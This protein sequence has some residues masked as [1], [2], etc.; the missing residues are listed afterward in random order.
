[1]AKAGSETVNWSQSTVFSNISDY[2]DLTRDLD[3]CY[4]T[5]EQLEAT[6]MHVYRKQVSRKKSQTD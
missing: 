5:A 3:I 2:C 1:V 4:N 6:V